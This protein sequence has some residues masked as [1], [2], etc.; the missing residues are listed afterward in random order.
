MT[1]LGSNSI[2]AR[3]SAKG[4]QI[5]CSFLAADLRHCLLT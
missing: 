5:I 4:D 3:R 2:E 1:S